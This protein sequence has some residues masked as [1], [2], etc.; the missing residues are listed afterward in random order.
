MPVIPSDQT[1]HTRVVFSRDVLK[2]LLNF[3]FT[4]VTKHVQLLHHLGTSP[5]Q[6]FV[7]PQNCGKHLWN[8][9]QTLPGCL[10]G[11]GIVKLLQPANRYA[12]LIGFWH[13]AQSVMHSN[14]E[15]ME[16]KET[17]LKKEEIKGIVCDLDAHKP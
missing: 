9:G 1:I 2:S 17:K 11:C 8:F 4:A 6:S 16:F 7:Q 13:L 12:E 15:L 14:K 3:K 5:Q 10:D